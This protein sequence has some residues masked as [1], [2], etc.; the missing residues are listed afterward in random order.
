[1]GCMTRS[2][3]VMIMREEL[4]SIVT[5]LKRLCMIIETGVSGE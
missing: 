2:F 3:S 4:N 1:M 5:G